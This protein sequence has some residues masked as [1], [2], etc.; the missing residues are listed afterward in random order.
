MLGWPRRL[1]FEV[2]MSRIAIGTLL[3]MVLGLTALGAARGQ[4]PQF[5][6][7]VNTVSVYTTVVDPA[8]RLVPNLTQA[9]FEILA[10]GQP[11]RI[12]QFT[13]G[14]Q[15]IT[16]V[17]MLDRSVSM[18]AQFAIERAA[19]E[20]FVANLT[21]GDRAR[22]G[23]FNGMIRIDPVEFTGDRDELIRA[24]HFDLL[25]AGLTPLWNATTVAMNALTRETGRRVVLLFS[26]G[27]NNP[28]LPGRK[29]STLAQVRDRAEADDI[30]IYAIGL[31]DG[32]D[33][34][35]ADPDGGA[36]RGPVAGRPAR[37]QAA[38]RGFPP[39]GGGP[40]NGGQPPSGGGPGRGTPSG[41]PIGPGGQPI[42]PAGSPGPGV[43]IP[44]DSLFGKGG[45]G[46]KRCSNARPRPALRELAA[47]GGGAYLEIQGGDD[48]GGIFARLADELHHQYLLGFTITTLDNRPHTLEVRARDPKL[49]VRARRSYLA[50]PK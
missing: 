3:A 35:T 15:P 6:A 50:A 48:L 33:Q 40:D 46:E 5:R 18:E 17:L 12:T 22:V 13:N 44:I 47:D 49:T 23:S 32:C 42:V 16:V 34:L 24:L 9:D 38:Q 21:A 10:D 26:D 43:S 30:M 20:S 25:D 14:L 31:N 28:G 37:R 4:D 7:G 36:P 2:A 11:Q 8:G 27:D 1:F 41:P 39:P 19:A 29:T 45:L